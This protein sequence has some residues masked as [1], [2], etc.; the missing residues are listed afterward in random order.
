MRQ[1]SEKGWEKLDF[2]GS[3]K[4]G[5]KGPLFAGSRELWSGTSLREMVWDRSEDNR[6][7]S[8][9]LRS[10]LWVS[11]KCLPSQMRDASMPLGSLLGLFRN[12]ERYEKAK[13]QARGPSL[14]DRIDLKRL[15]K[16]YQVRAGTC[17]LR[18]PVRHQRVPKCDFGVLGPKGPEDPK[19][20]ILGVFMDS[21]IIYYKHYLLI[22]LMNDVY[23]K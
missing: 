6:Q 9:V 3:Q 7:E 8:A 4:Q 18:K 15:D 10:G 23:N 21:I 16:P 17:E 5:P 19:N 22:R 20:S 14:C 1:I 13:T 12:V 2:G 11:R